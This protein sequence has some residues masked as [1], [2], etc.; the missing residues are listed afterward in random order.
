MPLRYRRMPDATSWRLAPRWGARLLLRR[1]PE[2]AAPNPAATSGYPLATL[3]VDRSRGEVRTG[4]PMH[5]HPGSRTG[6]ARRGPCVGN[7]AYISCVIIRPSPRSPSRPGEAARNRGRARARGRDC[8]RAYV[9]A[10]PPTGFRAPP[11]ATP[12][13]LFPSQAL[14]ALGADASA[15]CLPHPLLEAG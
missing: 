15:T 13:G 2:V 3:R 12:R 10:I 1:C 8:S 14:V 6:R 9:S 11:P 5:C 4:V 7:G